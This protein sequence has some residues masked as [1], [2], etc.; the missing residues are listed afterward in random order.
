MPGRL[1]FLTVSPA[2]RQCFAEAPQNFAGRLEAGG[3]GDSGTLWGRDVLSLAGYVSKA[4]R[5][6]GQASAGHLKTPEYVVIQE[7]FGAQFH[8]NNLRQTSA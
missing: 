8:A 5:V 6:E 3:L 2:R 4:Q 7:P 1:K